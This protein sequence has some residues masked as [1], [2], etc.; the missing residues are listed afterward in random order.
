M[1]FQNLDHM[2]AIKAVMTPFP[3]SVDLGES[4]AAA[5]RMMREHEVRHLPVSDEGKLVGEISQRD[6]GVGSKPGVGPR[7]V[8][9]LRVADLCVSD[10]YVV[11]LNTRLDE[12]LR[13]MAER[14]I[15]SALVVKGEKLVGIFTMSDACWVLADLLSARFRGPGDDEAA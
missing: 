8:S 9:E 1:D 6:I 7:E 2:P 4:V 10:A 11:E 5:E 3:Y 13:E 14:R 12:V 15:G